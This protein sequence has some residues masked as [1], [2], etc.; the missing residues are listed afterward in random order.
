MHQATHPATALATLGPHLSMKTPAGNFMPHKQNN[1][2]VN[3]KFNLISCVRQP[4]KV[5]SLKYPAPP[6]TML[7]FAEFKLFG[8][9]SFVL[10]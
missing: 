5:S 1:E 4:G 3:I 2:T 10:F 9:L 8:N 7:A 6:L